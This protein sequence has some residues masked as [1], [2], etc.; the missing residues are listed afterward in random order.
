MYQSG[1]PDS[2]LKFKTADI[3]MVLL[4]VH[5]LEQQ[6]VRYTVVYFILRQIRHIVL[7]VKWQK[8][9]IA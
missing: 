2:C 7:S 9:Y 1:S 3:V 6:S 4:S 5:H 8:M